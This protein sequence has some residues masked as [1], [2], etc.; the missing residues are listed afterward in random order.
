MT[1]SSAPAARAATMQR[2]A[3]DMGA[4]DILV[5]RHTGDILQLVGGHGRGAGWAGNV[6]I[7]MA[8]EPMARSV[9]R[10]GRP[11]RIVGVRVQRIL[12]PYWCADATVLPVGDEHLVVA[13]GARPP[14]ASKAEMLR[15][16]TEAVAACGQTSSE[17]LLADELE[18]VHAVRALMDC[19]PASVL[20][21][22][23]HVAAVAAESLSCEIG[24]VLMRLPDR[25]VVGVSRADG[26]ECAD[27]EAL[28]AELNRLTDS[29]GDG[30][31]MEQEVPP[32][33]RGSGH[34]A[35]Q[36]NGADNRS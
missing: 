2:V 18:V 29:I 30:I 23:R 8:Q 28:C 13:G 9:I 32:P 7:D 25:N 4:A 21:A 24:A 27:D 10:S 19:R 15:Y 35:R 3:R 34:C 12:G 6:H 14:I 1:S 20:D 31:L 17:K 16:A 36:P 22:A 26:S 11:A 33:E 5:L